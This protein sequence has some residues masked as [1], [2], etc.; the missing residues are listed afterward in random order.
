MNKQTVGCDV[1]HLTKQQMQVINEVYIK[2]SDVKETI[3]KECD[4][5]L[6]LNINTNCYEAQYQ[7]KQSLL[8]LLKEL[9]LDKR[10]DE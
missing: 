8:R 6:N 3:E 5:L 4:I 2:R 10:G 9:G 1:I 7:H